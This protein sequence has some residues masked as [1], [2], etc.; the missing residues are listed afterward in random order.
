MG[1]ER[2]KYLYIAIA[3]INYYPIG[4]EYE[5]HAV[6]SKLE[7]KIDLCK[8]RLYN[9]LRGLVLNAECEYLATYRVNSRQVICA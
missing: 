1:H 6:R 9:T 4:T 2:V 8:L 7:F 3:L 5:Q